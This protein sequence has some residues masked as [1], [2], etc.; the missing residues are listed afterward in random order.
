[1]T[2]SHVKLLLVIASFLFRHCIEGCVASLEMLDERR[3]KLGLAVKNVGLVR[4]PDV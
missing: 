2:W 4:P 3:E 1:M